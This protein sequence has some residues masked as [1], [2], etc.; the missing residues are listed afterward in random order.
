MTAGDGPE[1]AG[2]GKAKLMMDAGAEPGPLRMVL[3]SHAAA[4]NGFVSSLHPVQSQE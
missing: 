3:V 1:D 2:D 4:V